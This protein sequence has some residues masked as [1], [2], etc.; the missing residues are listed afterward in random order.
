VMILMEFLRVT[1]ILRTL[2]KV[3]RPLTWAAG[4]PAQAGFTV[5]TSMT[6]GLAYGAGTVIAESRRGHLSKTEQFRTNVFIGTTH[7]LF[8][9]TVLFLLVGASVFWIV[10]PRVILGCLAVRVFELLRRLWLRLRGVKAH[11]VQ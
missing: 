6:L 9:D 3:V 10:V 1:G 2:T 4:L 5:M 11:P 7:S 8:E